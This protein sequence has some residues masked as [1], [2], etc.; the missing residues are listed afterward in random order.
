MNMGKNR[1]FSLIELLIVMVV[2][3]IIL[4]LAVPGY[5]QFM[6]RANRADATTALLRLQAAQ[7]RFYIQ[8]GTYASNAQMAAA[9]PAGLGITGTERNYYNLGIQPAAGGLVVGYTA[10]ATVNAAEA[11]KDDTDCWVFATSESGQ[12]TAVTNGG[13][14]MTDKCWR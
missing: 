2:L 8:N 4:G 13:S 5:R 9:P 7:E 1:G 11:Q 12:H 6:M 10:T 3:S 14:D